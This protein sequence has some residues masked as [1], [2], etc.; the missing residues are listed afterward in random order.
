MEA[1]V[2]SRSLTTAYSFHRILELCHRDKREPRQQIRN[3]LQKGIA[4]KYRA[5][6][7]G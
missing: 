6:D 1:I 2:F 7:S 4:K 3:D 5:V